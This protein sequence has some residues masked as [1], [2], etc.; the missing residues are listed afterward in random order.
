MSDKDNKSSGN[1][2]HSCQENSEGGIPIINSY[3]PKRLRRVVFEAAPY[4]KAN[5]ERDTE[6]PYEP[7]DIWHIDFMSLEGQWYLTVIDKFSKYAIIKPSEKSR[8][9]DTI[10]EI[11]ALIDHTTTAQHH[12]SNSDVERLHNTIQELYR[13][14]R[15]SDLDKNQKILIFFV[16]AFKFRKLTPSENVIL[17]ES[18]P[19][20]LLEGRW[21]IIHK[22][23][24]KPI[25]YNLDSIENSMKNAL[26][27]FK[28]E[29]V[30]H[31][32]QRINIIL[33]HVKEHTRYYKEYTKRSN[34][35]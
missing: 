31:I 30:K 15:E 34:V 13:L 23:D 10:A 3:R 7:M 8:V 1:T 14:Q 28:S 26:T 18:K 22:L 27:R 35:V 21:A 33:E 9:Y 16:T 4:K 20:R 19:T 5:Y 25:R 11:F 17:I 2:I 32:Y 29:E 24:I 12:K 6:T